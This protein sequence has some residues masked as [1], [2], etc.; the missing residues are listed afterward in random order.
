MR[1][2]EFA[3]AFF[4]SFC[5]DY[6]ELVETRAD[7][8]EGDAAAAD[9][10]AGTMLALALS[11]ATSY[12]FA[13]FLPFGDRRGLA[14]VAARLGAPCRLA[15]GQRARRGR[16]RGM[17]G[18]AGGRRRTGWRSAGRRPPRSGRCGRR[19][20]VLPSRGRRMS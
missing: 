10:R 15:V 5:D 11:G 6:V 3:E 13:P 12:L 17:V 9:S 16:Q 20:A 2:E 4:W 18:A 7:N 14:V 8:G 1:A 19:C